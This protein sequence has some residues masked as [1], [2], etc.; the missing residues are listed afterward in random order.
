[1][2]EAMQ[3]EDKQKRQRAD[4]MHSM[5]YSSGPDVDLWGAAFYQAHDL[6]KKWFRARRV[7][8]M[9][10][11]QT[12]AF[13]VGDEKVPIQM[14]AF[15]VSAYLGDLKM[16]RLFLDY[17]EE[18]ELDSIANGIDHEQGPNHQRVGSYATPLMAAVQGRSIS[19]IR[20]LQKYCPDLDMDNRQ[21][22]DAEELGHIQAVAYAARHGLSQIAELLW[23]EGASLVVETE[24]RYPLWMIAI[25]NKHKNSGWFLQKAADERKNWSVVETKRGKMWGPDMSR[26]VVNADLFEVE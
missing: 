22:F 1:M 8:N 6:A 18:H 14:T 16:M 13:S 12:N 26:P 9:Q 2:S 11:R 4:W 21:S 23:F 3:Q 24:N 5:R 19:A 7:G 10:F 17:C 20:T 15:A 25:N